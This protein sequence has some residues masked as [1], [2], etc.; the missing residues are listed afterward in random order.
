MK[1]LDRKIRGP[2][3]WVSI[4]SAMQFMAENMIRQLVPLHVETLGATP[5]TVGIVVSAFN[6]LP[7]FLAIPGGVIVDTLG[8]R[9]MIAVASVVMALALA[10]L[11]LFPSIPVVA[12]A[13]LLSGVGMVLVIL[14]TQAYVS[15]LGE[16]KRVTANFAY[17][18]FAMSVG[19]LLG[20]PVGGYVADIGGYPASFLAAAIMV[21]FTLPIL[22]RLP[23]L[24]PREHGGG[25]ARDLV[26]GEMRSALREMP[27]LLRRKSVQQA[28]TVSIVAL[29][30]LS[31]RNSF[32]PVYLESIGFT[33]TNI[34][35]LISI[36]SLVAL[37]CRPFLPKILDVL[38]MKGL[39]VGALVIGAAGTVITPF[40]TGTAVLAFAAVLI[41]ITT[42]FTQP[43]SMVLMAE[44]SQNGRVGLAMG[45][46]QTTNQMGLF[47]GPVIYGLAV[48]ARGIGAA[49]ILA[50]GVL[51]AA[52]ALTPFMGFANRKEREAGP[53]D[54]TN[55]SR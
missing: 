13:Q 36:Q 41:G 23:E 4:L 16:G 39:L 11:A 1:S 15:R 48:S 8:Y 50:T 40:I 49:F 44:G 47:A 37:I 46:R 54:P 35:L 34:G 18:S 25:S 22:L 21:I 32:Y 7:L 31:L 53:T 24:A 10:G 9:A 26:V 14:A 38:G 45:L 17:Y 51:L 6:F 28:L 19:F 27:A 43:I 12:L 30:V 29:F 2:L 20:P 42:T 3:M 52:A 5:E 55:P 33:R